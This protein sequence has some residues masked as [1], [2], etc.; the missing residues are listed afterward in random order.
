MPHKSDL[1]PRVFTDEYHAPRTNGNLRDNL[2]KALVLLKQ[3]GWTVHRGVLRDKNFDPFEF[4]ILLDS[5]SSSAWERITLPF[6]ARLKKLGINA[7]VR[8]VDLIQY[9]NRVDS[10]DYDM[11][12]SVWGQSLSPGNEQRYFWGSAAADS[13]ASF[14]FSGI[15]SPVVDDLIEDVI[16]A[17]SRA[18]LKTAVHAL[19]RVL[20]WSF[21]VIPH[22]HTPYQ[23]FVFWDKF[24]MP[25][26]DDKPIKGTNIY[27]WWSK[28]S[29]KK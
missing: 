13:N 14:N 5:V 7:K 16:Q 8:V 18:E 3:A 29:R 10:F 22:W 24:G 11:I 25:A 20:L 26:T 27:Y 1:P 4:E 15:K 21:L 23:S 28:P 2:Q 17:K 19:D 6:I 12:V 9:K